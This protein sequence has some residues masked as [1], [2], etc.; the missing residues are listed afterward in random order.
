MAVLKDNI[1][2]GLPYADDGAIVA[3]AEVAG[4]T[5]FVNRHPHGFDM[6]VGERGE[7]LSGGQRQSVGLA[8]AG[9]AQRPRAAAGRTDQ[10][11][12]TSPP[13]RP[14]PPSWRTSAARRRWCW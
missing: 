6:N 7:S 5:D 14:S 9:A 13:S 11:N 1:T 2:F 12:E 4:M 3:A 8:R 10:R